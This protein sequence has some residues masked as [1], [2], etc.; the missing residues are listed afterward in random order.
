MIE[1]H[2]FPVRLIN[3]S[4]QRCYAL[5]IDRKKQTSIVTIKKKLIFIQ[6]TIYQHMNVQSNQVVLTL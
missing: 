2:V 3:N 1:N 4:F 5:V 6:N